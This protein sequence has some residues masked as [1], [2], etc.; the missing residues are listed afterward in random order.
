MFDFL[1]K[2]SYSFEGKKEDEVVIIFLH[3]HWYTLF[4]KMLFVFVGA[5]IPVALVVVFGS[6]ILQYQMMSVFVLLWSLWIMILWFL[7]FYILTMYTLETWVVT[8]IRIINSTQCGFFD[9]RI[10]ELSLDNIQDVSVN[11][12]GMV[13]TMMNYGQVEI[14]TAATERRFNFINVP[15]PQTVKDEIMRLV[16]EHKKVNRDRTN[17]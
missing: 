8:N 12:E 1:T 7:T 2:T 6:L 11:M 4:S 5:L 14:Q 15:N 17:L 9:R 13:P 3:R 16:A 10:S